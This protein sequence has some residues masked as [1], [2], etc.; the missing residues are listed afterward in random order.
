MSY[1]LT[2]ADH[3]RALMDGINPEMTY[4]GN[5]AQWREVARSRLEGILG[6][7]RM[8]KLE[9]P[10]LNVRSVWKREHELGTIEKIYFASEKGCDVMAYVCI[11]HGFK[12]PGPFFVCVPGH[13]TGAH[14]S[15]AVD[16]ND[17]SKVI[18]VQGDRDYGLVCMR[19]GVAA[20]CIEQRGFGERE[21]EHESCSRCHPP[22]AHALLLGR[23]LIGERIYDIDRGIDYLLSRGDAD[24][25]RIGVM[26]NSGGG[27]ASMFAG[28]L[29]D[30]LTHVMPSSSFSTFRDSIAAMHHCICNY[31]PGL[32]VYG[33]TADVVGLAAPKPMVV[34]NGTEDP[35]FPLEAAQKE[36]ARLQQIYTDAGAPGNCRHVIAEG[37]H[38]FYAEAAWPVMLEYL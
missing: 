23:T 3:H 4:N 22:S 37:G 11:P 8:M 2:P 24:P 30:R 13:G 28:G 26:G 14:N 10:E 31:V 32:M 33:E 20:L 17:D 12:V 25:K 9:R 7:D 18:E 19:Y 21:D 1:S 38:R 16:L 27:T 6:L 35:I 29:L 36:F 34:V 15:V 5:F